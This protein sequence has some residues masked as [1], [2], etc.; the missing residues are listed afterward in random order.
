MA[1]LDTRI[2][3]N[4]CGTPFAE[5]GIATCPECGADVNEVGTWSELREWGRTRQRGRVR[6][7]FWW[8]LGW[9][10]LLAGI[11]CGVLAWRGVSDWVVY[12]FTTLLPLAGYFAGRQ[13][14]KRAEHEYAAWEGKAGGR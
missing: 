10:G 4:N 11:Q 2:R 13:V 14:W 8:V 1:W 6:F 3:C 7:L 12:S 9:G 5:Q